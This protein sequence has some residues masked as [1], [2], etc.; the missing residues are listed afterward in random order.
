VR[1][2]WLAA[3][4]A[5]CGFT[6]PAAGDGGT[7]GGER[8]IDMAGSAPTSPRKVTFNNAS[9][10]TALDDFPVLVP[11][12]GQVDYSQV[13]DPRKDLR[14]EDPSNGAT[15]AYEVETWTPNGESL[16][17]VRVPRISPFPAPAFILMHF[18]H[19]AG[20]AAPAS[21]WST[22]EQ[23]NHFAANPDDSTS[24]NHDGTVVGAATAAGFLGNAMTFSTGGDRVTFAGR[25]FDQWNEGTIEMW[26]RPVYAAAGD[27]VGEPRVLS[28][29]GALQLGRFY[30][31]TTMALVLQ[32]DAKWA[33]NSHSELHPDLPFNMW[34]HVAWTY[35][36]QAWRSYRNGQLAQ[37]DAI[38]NHDFDASTGPLIL[39]DDVSSN[40]AH[41]QIDEL[42]ISKVH[43]SADWLRAQQ[44]SMTRNF[45]S[46]SDP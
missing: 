33:G 17:W 46:F 24:Q 6:V 41:M 26:I 36:G 23:V 43:R 10:T 39:G 13:V 18:G 40:G 7:T 5:G 4:C 19:D 8:P 22:Y 30:V 11:I 32:I 44:A 42:R 31:D 2:G 21:V 29:G 12:A 3:L 37:T 16:V 15:L 38:G 20:N 1:L 27:I 34:T 28:N 9:V 14:F 45:V 35:D 25:V